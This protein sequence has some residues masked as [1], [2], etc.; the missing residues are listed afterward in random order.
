MLKLF[1]SGRY[2]GR[3]PSLSPHSSVLLILATLLVLGFMTTSLASYFASRDAIR[4]NIIDT[5][6]PLTSDNAYSEI[7]RD[8]V[9]PIVIS[10]MMAHDTFLRDWVLD[11]ET[12]TP[13]ITNY[14][15]E[16][17]N[18]YGAVTTFF[19]SDKTQKYYQTNGV[20]KMVNPANAHDTWYYRTRKAS[21]PY[22]IEV[23]TDEANHGRL[24]IFIDTQVFDYNHRFI[25]I[26]GIGLNVRS[27][28]SMIDRYKLR[29]DRNVYFVGDDG[30]VVL[31]GSAGGPLDKKAGDPIADIPE[32]KRLIEATQKP[33][34]ESFE[35]RAKGTHH[36]ANVR[37]I[38]EL[39]WYLVVDK[40]ELGPLAG[41]RHT[42]YMN[43]I[44]CAVII[45]VALALMMMILGRYRR[46]IRTAE[47]ERYG[48][49]SSLAHDIRAP[50]S[51][52]LALVH[53]QRTR[54]QTSLPA[55]VIDRIEHYTNRASELADD[56]VH[57]ARAETQR[58]SF[59]RTNVGD[60]LM[61]AIDEIAPK[62]QSKHIAIEVTTPES[63]CFARADRT[64]LTRVFI[65]VLD[66]AIKYSPPDTKIMCILL[67]DAAVSRVR[68]VISD[69][70]YGI[71]PEAHGR[72]FKRFSRFRLEDQP[73]EDGIGLGL[74]FVKT[75]MTRH[76]GDV[77]LDSAPGR[78][79][80]VLLELVAA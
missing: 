21:E 8:L 2:A 42:L 37:Y 60:I 80:T 50:H 22:A 32:L 69:N 54:G 58:Y 59:E 30:Y 36:F 64:L 43:L 14:L 26:T 55:D 52:I 18:N 16:I 56:F 17:M 61:D 79:T 75:V 49:L 72:L 4:Q 46:Q 77:T 11:G 34:G 5:E 70:G 51:S 74:V 76:G 24:T 73:R 28:T 53:M 27:I 35:Y 47:N 15:R 68:C 3:S 67:L 25:G 71:A 1:F 44:V 63:V 33:N 13:R 40:S 41:V 65:N 6:L 66:N 48:A 39:R 20:L 62:A 38:P 57:L 7:Q 45:V 10:N 12:D 31:V 23:D 9:Q 29:F 19:I 78:G